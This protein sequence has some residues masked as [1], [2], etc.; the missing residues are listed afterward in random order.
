M[1]PFPAP[2]LVALQLAACGGPSFPELAAREP[3]ALRPGMTAAAW[4]VAHPSDGFTSFRRDSIR[5][6]HDRWCGRA[7]SA[8][9][10][11][12]GA[13]IVRYAYFYPPLPPESLVLPATGGP[14]LTREQ[15]TLGTVWLE[16]PASVSAAGSAVEMSVRNAL[17][18]EPAP[19][20]A[21]PD[22]LFGPLPADSQ[23]RLLSRL[24]GADAMLLGLHFFGAAA[25]RT[26]G[27]WQVDSTIIVS[28]FDRGL[29]NGTSEGRVLAFA[30]LPIA[31]LGAFDRAEER[32]RAEER[33]T[34]ELAA[35]AARL[36]ELDRAK[37]ERLLAML[38]AAESAYTGRHKVNPAALDSAAVAVL[39]AW[40]TSARGL[41]AP[42]RAAALLAADPVLGSSAL[43]YVRAQRD[44][45]VTRRALERLGAAFARNELGGGYNYVH[46]WLDDAL[47]LDP[48]GRAGTLATMAL[49]RSGFNRTGM[50]GGG[51]QA[52]RPGIATG[53][54]AVGTTSG[55]APAGGRPRPRGAR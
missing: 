44:D 1:I 19:I 28:A 23:R 41:P 8:A 30:F 14:T 12:G 39:S 40:I 32:A 34:S 45:S 27:R 18:R 29:A 6:N 11:A 48:R 53:E 51:A 43:N 47:R 42:R 21:G 22:V 16:T 31:E 13:Q 52:V 17:P 50:C 9:T 33:H 49:L 20:T 10:G 5:E 2:A 3:A 37:T 54:R 15:C 26:P 36:S 4:L 46:T 55:P 38:T 25:W 35:D 7:S 24:P